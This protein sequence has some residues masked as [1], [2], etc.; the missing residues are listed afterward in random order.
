[1]LDAWD[2]ICRPITFNME[3]AVAWFKIND[4]SIRW[5]AFALAA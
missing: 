2:F 3:A 4:P 5:G 1:M